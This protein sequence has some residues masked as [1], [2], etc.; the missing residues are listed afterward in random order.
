MYDVSNVPI[1]TA[2]GK[3]IGTYSSNRIHDSYRAA[4]AFGFDGR[5]STNVTARI[6]PH[7]INITSPTPLKKR[8]SKKR[9]KILSLNILCIVYIE[10]S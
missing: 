6:I 7:T 4:I 3:N 10:I 2:R 8:R 5:R 9:V 1:N